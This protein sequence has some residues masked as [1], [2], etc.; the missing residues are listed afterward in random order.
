MLATEGHFITTQEEMVI[1]V[2]DRMVML[3]TEGHLRAAEEERVWRYLL[4][5]KSSVHF[6]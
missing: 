1:I 6:R 5:L 2:S 4:M 3:T